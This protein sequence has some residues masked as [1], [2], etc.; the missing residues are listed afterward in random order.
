MFGLNEGDLS[1]SRIFVAIAFKSACFDRDY[2][3]E[4]FDRLTALRPHA[5]VD[6]AARFRKTILKFL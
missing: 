3:V 5:D 1:G 4:H 2:L 6:D